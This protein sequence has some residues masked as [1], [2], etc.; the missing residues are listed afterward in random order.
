MQVLQWSIDCATMCDGRQKTT[1]GGSSTLGASPKQGR[2][3]VSVPYLHVS[4]RPPAVGS[5]F[6]PRGHAHV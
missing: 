2:A 3:C 6:S 4:G 5:D 1:W